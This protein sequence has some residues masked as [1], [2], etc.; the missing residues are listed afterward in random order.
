MSGKA[1]QNPTLWV[2]TRKGAWSLHAQDGR[3]RWALKGPHFHGH[4]VHHVVADPR[5]PRL[6]L[7]SVRTGH[8]GPTLMRSA[9]GGKRWSEAARPPAFHKK[10]DPRRKTQPRV[11]D[12]TFFLTPGHASE[13]GTWW[14]GTSPQGLF[15]TEDDGQTWTGVDAINESKRMRPWMGT[16]QDGT[17]DGPKLHSITLDPRDPKHLLFG[18]SGGGVHESFDRG[19]TWAARIEGMEVV[20]GFPSDQPTFHDPHCIVRSPAD[21]TRLYQQNHCG[22]YRLD[23]CSPA[24]VRIGRQM[25]KSVGDVGF[26]IVAHPRDRDTAW[27]FPMDA[28]DVWPRTAVAGKPAAYVTRDGGR[29]WQR[30]DQGLPP[31]QAWWTIKRQAMAAD[32][33]DPVGLYVGNTGG[34]LWMG[35]EEGARWRCIARHLPEI[36]AISVVSR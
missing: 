31:A 24:W 14:A 8:L 28:N 17:P 2:A 30:Q 10:D 15:F 12:H 11:V 18:M 21:P 27:V 20:G 6:V 13:R 9:D 16:A 34:E 22:I 1:S 29:R 35:A 5:N 25:P 33:A 19:A 36:Y 23:E 32:F 4:I 26:P 7:A 3:E